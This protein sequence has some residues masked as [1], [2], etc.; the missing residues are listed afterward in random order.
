MVIF[1]VYCPQK[2]D[3]NLCNSAETN[4]VTMLMTKN[5]D[6]KKYSHCTDTM[7]QNTLEDTKHTND[8]ASVIVM[9][10]DTHTARGI[11]NMEKQ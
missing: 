7:Y 6:E 8:N 10:G 5:A 2:A 3:Q 4:L 9:F 1:W 11:F